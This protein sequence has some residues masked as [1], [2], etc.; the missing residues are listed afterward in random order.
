MNL[1]QSWGTWAVPSHTASA[2]TAF[3]RLIP[4]YRGTGGPVIHKVDGNGKMRDYSP[5]AFTHISQIVYTAAGTAHDVV[6]MRPLNWTYLTQAMTANDTTAVLAADP[7]LY[8][9]TYKYAL[10]DDQT[11]PINTADNGI[12]TSDYVAFQL[13]DGTWH[14]ST[15]ASVSSLTATL[16]TATP[17]VTGGGAAAGTVVYFFGAAANVN[18]QTGVAHVA[19]TSVVNTRTSLLPDVAAGSISG[20]NRGDPLI[21]YS[22]NGTNAGTLNV[23]CGFY[24]DK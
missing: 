3:A 2:G 15:V 18:P 7:G 6:V 10:P 14:F 11:K 5:R 23:C 9:T 17:N 20:L 19:L 16:D 21:V 4:P 8:A 12:A 13:Y 22:A 24:A 1:L